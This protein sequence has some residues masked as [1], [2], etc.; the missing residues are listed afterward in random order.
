MYKVCIADD[1]PYVRMGIAQ[2]IEISGLPL[3]V[4]GMAED[5]E[6]AWEI[7]KKEKPDIFFLDIRMPVKDGLSFI[8]QVR[9]DDRTSDTKFI[10][11]S[12]Y[13]DFIYMQ[14][15]IQMGVTDY[16]K[17]PIQQEAF[18]KMLKGIISKLEEER[19][20]LSKRRIRGRLVLWSDFYEVNKYEEV[21][22]SF[23]LFGQNEM[24]NSELI[25][26]L[27]EHF[28]T[29]E[30]KYLYFYNTNHILIIYSE[31]ERTRWEILEM[32][33][34][35]VIRDRQ[36]IVFS[37]KG[38]LERI[39]YL[40]EGEVNRKFYPLLPAVSFCALE[41]KKVREWKF[42][43]IEVALENAQDSTVDKL[44]EEE[45]RMKF[46]DVQNYTSM[47]DFYKSILSVLAS[48][49]THQGFMVPSGITDGLL[50]M[51][52]ANFQQKEEV[53]ESILVL[54][55]EFVKKLLEKKNKS[56]IVDQIIEYIKK[57]Y[58]EELALTSLAE[59]FFLAPTYL[60]RKFKNT[61][62]QSVMQ[63]LEEYRIERATE[64]L[65]E[66]ALPITEVAS[67]VGYNDPNYFSRAFKK[68]KGVTPKEYR[69]ES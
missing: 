40:L 10:V 21:E 4:V 36:I 67:R 58:Q 20:I 53:L 45:F 41:E 19:V 1:E 17:K 15:A 47:T 35:D 33:T 6:K 32:L 42:Q 37:G 63:Y 23:I 55:R 11:I 46:S 31:R 57:H 51:F 38:Y 62:G 27:V 18:T 9:K 29:E 13:D 39:L 14:K 60:A 52:L 64:F 61:T 7:Y 56:E 34:E 16:V 26:S 49:Y 50:P 24:L 5:G 2:R 28:S 22:G 54:T 3:L 30:W 59:E 66:S 69:K 8:E 65:S 68:I 48:V 12:G 44:I 43:K 25:W